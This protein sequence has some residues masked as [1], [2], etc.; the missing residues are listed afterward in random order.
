VS[1]GDSLDP[2]T[3][4]PLESEAEAQWC[5]RLMSFSEPWV[6]LG[7]TYQESLERMRDDARERYLARLGSVLAGF[8]VLNLKGA[9]VGY[10]QSV[11]VAPEQ[12]RKGIGARLVGFAEER[13]LRESPNVF[14]CV[15]SFNHEAR[16]LYER[17][18]YRMVGT[19]ADYL[20]RGHS[21]LLLRKT[22]GPIRE[23]RRE[24]GTG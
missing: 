2:L 8:L 5:A 12:R 15:S 20:V 14:L 13:I 23:F 18:G 10:I 6:T 4:R 19:L 21:E 9:F 11:C 7:R 1:S 22:I 3:I 17:L 24:R 16:R